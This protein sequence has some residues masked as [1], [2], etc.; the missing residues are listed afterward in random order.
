MFSCFYVATVTLKLA[1]LGPERFWH[2]SP[3]RN[4]FDFFNVYGCF[5]AELACIYYGVCKIRVPPDLLR[6]V[7]LLHI[8]RIVRIL[9]YIQPLKQIATFVVRLASTYYRMGMILV[10][11]FYIY[12]LLGEQFFGGLIYSTNPDLADTAFAQANYWSMNFNDF[13]S[14]MVTLFVIMVVNNW[15]VITAAFIRAA[16]TRWAAAFFVS[17]YL[18]VNMIVLNILMALIIDCSATVQQELEQEA[19]EEEDVTKE[20]SSSTIE[21]DYEAVLRRL[22]LED[23]DLDVEQLPVRISAAKT[24]DY[25]S[26]KALAK[27][28]ASVP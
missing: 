1:V 25:G 26:T 27:K 15:F 13:N 14:G 9:H 11:L 10:V 2:I 18:L 17:F 16:G 5:M 3:V 28:R 24:Q 7:L 20:P 23:E 4:R 12:G 19:E 21:Y 6:G 22:L 8:M